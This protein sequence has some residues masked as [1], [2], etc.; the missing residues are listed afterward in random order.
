MDLI[1]ERLLHGGR[2]YL[3]PGRRSNTDEL[4]PIL[5]GQIFLPEELMI[6]ALDHQ[7]PVKIYD[8]RLDAYLPMYRLSFLLWEQDQ[9]NWKSK[10]RRLPLYRGNL[11]PWT[12]DIKD[13]ELQQL[14]RR[15]RGLKTWDKDWIVNENLK[16][17]S[18]TGTKD[19]NS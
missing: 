14:A 4:Y 11:N 1:D 2:G 9:H 13:W 10:K 19:I 16:H 6:F 17:L 18:E 7:H 8:G 15:L 5:E 3:Y 12:N